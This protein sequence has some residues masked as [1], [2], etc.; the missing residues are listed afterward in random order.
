MKIFIDKQNVEK[1]LTHIDAVPDNFLFSTIDGKE[2]IHLIDWEYAGMQDPHLDIA[3]FAIY[4]CYNKRQIDRL[5]DY[6]FEDS[7]SKQNR[8]KIYCYIAIAGLLWSNWC[9]YK[10][11]L[12]I[13]FGEYAEMQYKYAK[14]YYKLALQKMSELQE[15]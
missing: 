3:M 1:C 6:Y 15:G 9:E 13:E 7:C 12:G 8:V 5:I 14:K 10:R 4:S 11:H 2:E